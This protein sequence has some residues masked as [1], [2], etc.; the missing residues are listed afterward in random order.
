MFA[1]PARVRTATVRSSQQIRSAAE[2]TP[3]RTAST[4]A[5]NL[6]AFGCDTFFRK[7]RFGDAQPV[8]QLLPRRLLILQRTLEALDRADLTLE[9][10]HGDI[11]ANRD[12]PPN[13]LADAPSVSDGVTFEV[14]RLI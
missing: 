1:L 3:R 7:F 14:Q 4:L 13:Q 2:R 6:V 9:K 11:L 10:C 5:E 12:H 8:G